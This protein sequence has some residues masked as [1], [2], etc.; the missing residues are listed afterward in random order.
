MIQTCSNL[1]KNVFVKRKAKFYLYGDYFALKML[2]EQNI[3]SK[4]LKLAAEIED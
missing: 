2:D 3:A 1:A 4:V